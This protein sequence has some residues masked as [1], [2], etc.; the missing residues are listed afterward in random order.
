[1]K[2]KEVEE[3][4][5]TVLT[6][7]L[8]EVKGIS[9]SYG[10]VRALR[11]A[12]FT[13]RA[14]EVVAIAGDNGAGKSTLLKILSGIISSD[15]GEILFEGTPVA[16][17]SPTAATKLGIQTVYQELSLCGNLDTVEN[18]FLGREHRN[19]FWGFF[20]LSRPKMERDARSMLDELEIRIE[21]ID[22][23]VSML[24][25]GQRQCVAVCRAIL[26]NPKVVILDEPT[27]ALGVTQ[28]RDVLKLIDH[29][30]SQGRG[31]ILVSHDLAEVLRIADRVVVLRRGT[32]VADKPTAEWT[33]QSLVAAITG[34]TALDLGDSVE[35]A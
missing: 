28:T 33:E 8:I 22:S 6:S 1:L 23:P 34:A 2:V 30:R 4:P 26:G 31:V 19:K 16:I 29:L 13:V 15:G 20:R 9:K 3:M 17:H 27:A 7:P 12:D 35:G 14:G 5:S 21:K 11:H 24:S 18:I 32:S 25:G 10:A